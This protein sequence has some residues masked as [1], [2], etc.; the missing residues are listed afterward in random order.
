MKETR[1]L[2]DDNNNQ[3][4]HIRGAKGQKKTQSK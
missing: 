1:Y 3:D 4:E 2:Q